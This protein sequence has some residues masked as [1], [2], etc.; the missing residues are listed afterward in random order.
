[1]TSYHGGLSE[2]L[3]VNWEYESFQILN[4]FLVS[5]SLGV[6]DLLTKTYQDDITS[7]SCFCKIF[8]SLKI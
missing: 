3:D 5:F 4:Y 8:L 7:Q 2:I 6:V 1:M